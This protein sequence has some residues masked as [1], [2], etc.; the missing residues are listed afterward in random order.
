MKRSALIG[1]FA[2]VASASFLQ[3]GT[4]Q[5]GFD[6]DHHHV[7]KHL[8][9]AVREVAAVVMCPLDWFRHRHEHHA[10]YTPAPKKVVYAK[11]VAAKK[12]YA[13]PLK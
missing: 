4:A 5:A 10:A 6:H 2:L 7:R 1:A 9:D 12:A 3:T 11:K 13:T 8:H